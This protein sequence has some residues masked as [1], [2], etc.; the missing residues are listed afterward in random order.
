MTKKR[1]FLFAAF[2]PK[3]IDN[4]IIDD[5]TVIYLRELSKLGDIVYFQDNDVAESEL[6]KI[7]SLVLFANAKRHGEYDFGSYKR[8]FIY[9]RDNKLLDNYDYL[10]LVNDSVYGPF[11]PLLPHLENMEADN[12]DTVG[13]IYSTRKKP[14]YFQSWFVGMSKKVSTSEWFEAFITSVVKQKTKGGTINAYEHGFSELCRQKALRFKS[15]YTLLPLEP[16]THR[17]TKYYFRKGFP[18]IKKKSFT[19][20]RGALGKEVLYVL[21]NTAPELKAA[22]IKNAEYVYGKDYVDKFLTN[23]VLK[24][25]W[26]NIKHAIYRRK[27]S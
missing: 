7:A 18:F 10:Y 3:S 17:G 8:A 25:L 22:I 21:N 16:S 12:A 5:C 26:R 4:G 14:H 15:A 9:A 23:N 19:H 6:K 20:N 27:K 11:F 2:D 13:M 1:L 24:I